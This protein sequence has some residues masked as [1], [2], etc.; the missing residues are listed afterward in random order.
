MQTYNLDIDELILDPQRQLHF[1][2]SSFNRTRICS[3]LKKNVTK[4][5]P[6]EIRYC[7]EQSGIFSS[8]T[9]YNLVF[10]SKTVSNLVFSSKATSSL[11]FSSKATFITFEEL[12]H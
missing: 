6:N 9:T 4:D 12:I 1:V 5:I 8:K 7:A 10:S 2:P 3:K 11:V